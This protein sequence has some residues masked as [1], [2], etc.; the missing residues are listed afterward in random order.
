MAVFSKLSLAKLQT[1]HPAL[2][3]LLQEAIKQEDFTV[4]CGHRNE[5]E[6]EDAVRTKHSTQHWPN[7]KHNAIPSLA[8]D[9]APYPVDWQ[10]TARFARLA[11]YIERIAWEKAIPIR[12]GGD[13]NNNGRTKDERLIDMPHLELVEEK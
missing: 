2:Q 4:L 11:G 5:N 3:E 10:D 9:I 8:V 7:S 1:C 6:Q 12:W 13:W